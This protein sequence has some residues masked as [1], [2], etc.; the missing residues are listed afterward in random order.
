MGLPS[1]A[2]GK[3]PACLGDIKRHSFNPLEEGITA[4]SCILAWRIP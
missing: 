2:N 1:G 3:E 4:H